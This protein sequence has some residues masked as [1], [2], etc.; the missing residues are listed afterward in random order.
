[1]V[2]RKLRSDRNHVLY[3]LTNTKTGDFYIGMTVVRDGN[4][5]KSLSIRWKGHCYKAFVELKPWTMPASIRRHGDK[6]WL[7]EAIEVVRGKAA[8]HQREVAL[9]KALRPTLNEASN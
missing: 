7:H 9:I 1:M 4:V 3:R 5:K 8:A 2:K 6:C